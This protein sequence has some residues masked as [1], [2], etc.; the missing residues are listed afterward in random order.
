MS[1]PIE[2]LFWGQFLDRRHGEARVAPRVDPTVEESEV[3][4]PDAMRESCSFSA[5]GLVDE[6]HDGCTEGDDPTEP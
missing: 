2:G 5:S 3:V 4:V 6:Q 1:L